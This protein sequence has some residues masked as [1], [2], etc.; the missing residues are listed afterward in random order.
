[1]GR[2]MST[3]VIARLVNAH[4][5]VNMTHSAILYVTFAKRMKAAVDLNPAAIHNTHAVK[6]SYV[7]QAPRSA[8]D[9]RF[10]APASAI[11]STTTRRVL[12]SASASNIGEQAVPTK[13]GG[14][15]GHGVKAKLP[16]SV[17]DSAE[18]KS[19]AY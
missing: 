1:M 10:E 5:R 16:N 12:V 6:E 8:I 2:M 4:I 3:H 15:R 18:V 11:A 19:N 14:T 7:P 17:E 9:S 13:R